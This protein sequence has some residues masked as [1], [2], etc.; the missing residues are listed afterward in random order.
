MKWVTD[1]STVLLLISTH[2]HLLNIIP[3]KQFACTQCCNTEDIIQNDIVKAMNNYGKKMQCAI[4]LP[5]VTP[6]DTVSTTR[7]IYGTLAWRMQIRDVYWPTFLA[8]PCRA[9]Q[10]QAI[11]KIKCFER[12]ELNSTPPPNQ[13]KSQHSK[14]ACALL[15]TTASITIKLK[16]L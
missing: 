14:Q 13:K 1:R 4:T 5:A 9:L 10:C 16:I 6:S 8:Q 15:Q 11:L 7:Y 2:Q 3:F 12:T